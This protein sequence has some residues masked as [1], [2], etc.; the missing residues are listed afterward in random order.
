VLKDVVDFLGKG[1]PL[2]N[3]SDIR[4]PTL[5]VVAEWDRDTPL[6]MAQE[7]LSKLVNTPYKRE[8]VLA[9]GTHMVAVEKNR[10]ELIKEVQRFLDERR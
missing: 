7:V 5:L 4:V 10:M 6:F 9:E 2:Y 3:P 1:T 8:V